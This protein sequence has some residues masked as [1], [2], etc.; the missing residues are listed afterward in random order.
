MIREMINHFTCPGDL[1]VDVSRRDTTR[2]LSARAA[3]DLR[4]RR[5]RG[6][7][8][9]REWLRL[10]LIAQMFDRSWSDEGRPPAPRATRTAG[11]PKSPAVG[12]QPRSRSETPG[13]STCRRRAVS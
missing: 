11:M 4:E 8:T 6:G 7:V 10:T 9:G 12:S 5:N 3:R 1:G 13:L 2:Q